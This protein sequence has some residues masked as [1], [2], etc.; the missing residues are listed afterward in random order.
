MFSSCAFNS[1]FAKAPSESSSSADQRNILYDYAETPPKK[2][3][4]DG[5]LFGMRKVID[6]IYHQSFVADDV[7]DT[8]SDYFYMRYR[9]KPLAGI[10]DWKKFD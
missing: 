1:S 9:C 3:T 10:Y 5:E 2:N 7:E 8:P 6:G 4:R